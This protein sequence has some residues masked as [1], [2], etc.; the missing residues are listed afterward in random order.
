MQEQPQE[1]TVRIDVEDYAVWVAIY[2]NGK[3]IH[4]K[5]WFNKELPEEDRPSYDSLDREKLTQFQMCTPDGRLLFSVNFKPGTGGRLIWR[6]RVQN[7]PGYGVVPIYIVGKRGAF[8]A[9][10]LPDLTIMLDDNFNAE[11]AL[12]SEPESVKGE[13]DG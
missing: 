1:E 5:D 7:M 9:A 10:I 3:A 6:R 11:N 8:V 12:L 2:D 13:T 4:Q